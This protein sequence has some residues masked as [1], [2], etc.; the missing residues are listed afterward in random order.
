MT[1]STV[2]VLGIPTQ[3]DTSGLPGTIDA[4]PDYSPGYQTDTSA[5]ATSADAAEVIPK[6][7]VDDTSTNGRVMRLEIDGVAPATAN[8]QPMVINVTGF[9]NVVPPTP[10]ENPLH[11]FESYT[12][13]L[14]LHLVGIDAF[15]R[16]IS[17]ENPLQEYVPQNV[18][19][20]SAGRYNNSLNRNENFTED[21]YFE[22]LKLKTYINTTTRNRSSNIIECSFT[23]IEPNGFTLINRLLAAANQVNPGPGTYLQM[24]YML[25]IDFFGQRDGDIGSYSPIAGQTKYLP[26]R[27]LN[28][29]T[30]VSSKG[31][32]Y[33]VDAV[34]FNHQAFNQINVSLPMAT[35]V[36]G[37]KVTDIFGGSTAVATSLFSNFARSRERDESLPR[38]RAALDFFNDDPN[39][40]EYQNALNKIE[41]ALE[42]RR[43]SLGISGFCDAVNGWFKYI[44]EQN[45]A[46]QISS[47]SVV[48]DKEIGDANI[49][50][51]PATIAAT[52]AS[53]T[54][55]TDNRGTIQTSGTSS[56]SAKTSISFDGATINVP[57]GMT[58]DK[59]IDW[60]V[61]NSTYI[62]NQI[63][64]PDT[65][66]RIQTSQGIPKDLNQPLKWFKI[67]PRIKILDFDTRQNR[68][69]LDVTFFV[70]TF[71]LSAKHPFAPRGRTPGLVKQYNY[72]FT[73]KNKD[74]LD[75]A[76]DFNTLYLVEISANRAKNKVTET[77]V[78]IQTPG[79]NPDSG[80]V[81]GPVL[82][83]ERPVQQQIAPV[84][85]AIIAENAMTTS[86]P[87]GLT[88]NSVSAGDLQR[89]IM[90][91]AKGDM[92]SVTLKIIGDP[93]FIKQD[94]VF[95]NQNLNNNVGVLTPN[96][97][98][99][100]D[101]GELYVFLN[102]E[103]PVDY[104][105]TTGIADVKN[106]KFRY[107]EFSG[108]YKIITVDSIFNKGKFEQSLSLAKLFYDQEGFQNTPSDLRFNNGEPQRPLVPIARLTSSRYTGPSVNLSALNPALN[109]RIATNQIVPGITNAGNQVV[110]T[111]LNAGRQVI[112]RVVGQAVNS[113]TS[114]VINPISDAASRL[115]T[116][117]FGVGD[118]AS[119]SGF[120]QLSGLDFP[121][122]DLSTDVGDLSLDL[123]G[124]NLDN[125]GDIGDL[126]NFSIDIL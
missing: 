48:F 50:P 92:I 11:N 30:K 115:I 118:L 113:V 110:N 37:K 8:T 21:F 103:S 95:F 109:T 26:I 4:L 98:I 13:N 2:T 55:V 22:D 117:N 90:S 20:S 7:E 39:S 76:I 45:L 99:Y 97:S 85:T 82:N 93:H 121:S 75:L 83:T 10:M 58:I 72:I 119:G 5:V 108:V 16:M 81:Q 106:S 105:E 14:S 79:V 33:H 78:P 34:P 28:I 60:A 24:P 84:Q 53:S 23:L 116:N 61:R 122:L 49:I 35:S 101:G 42:Q 123:D 104:N 107:S 63:T 59:L 102:F 69:S 15:N 126:G 9:N 44:K 112:N 100:T 12:Y 25:Q 96:G 31:T 6:K 66:N 68:Y 41:T 88:Q 3:V 32:E 64:D 94:D 38:T 17:S 36:T 40:P 54:S 57:A 80:S 120:D 51:I 47:V 73:G 74:V 70:K 29:K 65:K 19:I 86:R 1:T 71:T 111:V 89:S 56:N 62:G 67:I 125:L 18:L 27:L 87:G 114:S 43:R 52:A 124:L 91:G 46:A 77:G